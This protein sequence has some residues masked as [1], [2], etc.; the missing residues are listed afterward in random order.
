MK[1][2]YIY[3][4]LDKDTG[5]IAGYR[6]IKSNDK[7]KYTNDSS[8]KKY[9]NVKFDLPSNC[10]FDL[11]PEPKVFVSKLSGKNISAV[12]KSVILAGDRENKLDHF[13]I[14]DDEDKIDL[15]KNFEKIFSIK[16][17][18][19]VTT[20]KEAV[21]FNVNQE[22]IFSKYTYSS[23]RKILNSFNISNDMFRALIFAAFEAAASSSV[24]Y[25]ISKDSG[26]DQVVENEKLIW[27]IYSF[28]P[29]QLIE[30]LGFITYFKLIEPGANYRLNANIKLR[31]VEDNE[32]NRSQAAKQ[33]KEDNYVFNLSTGYYT[34]KNI[35]KNNSQFLGFLVDA[36]EDETANQT[37]KQF[38]ENLQH[39]IKN[40]DY[41]LAKFSLVDSLFLLQYSKSFDIIGLTKELAIN[42]NS[43]SDD[44]K[45]HFEESFLKSV[46]T[47]CPEDATG[48]KRY[49]KLF[50]EIYNNVPTVKN[51]IINYFANQ[52]S[53]DKS[54][55]QV[56]QFE[57]ELKQ[58]LETE[59]LTNPNYTDGGVFLINS[60]FEKLEQ[61]SSCT[62]SEVVDQLCE[63]ASISPEL[64]LKLDLEYFFEKYE[65]R[66]LS[67]AGFE[68]YVSN[69]Y[70]LKKIL[71][72][73]KLNKK[74]VAQLLE[75]HFNICFNHLKKQ[76]DYNYG[77]QIKRINAFFEVSGVVYTYEDFS[78]C[79]QYKQYFEKHFIWEIENLPLLKYL[80]EWV[81]KFTKKYS[82]AKF[83][84]DAL[85]QILDRIFENM[86]EQQI[87]SE[88][89]NWSDD[90]VSCINNRNIK[91]K[92]I[93]LKQLEI[94]EDCLEERKYDDIKQFLYDYEEF[95]QPA[96][97]WIFRI[98]EENGGDLSNI[99]KFDYSILPYIFK[100]DIG[101]I[102]SIL[103]DNIKAW[104]CCLQELKRAGIQYNP[105]DWSIQGNK[106]LLKEHSKL[107]ED[108]KKLFNVRGVSTD[109]GKIIRNLLLL[110]LGVSI[111]TH[112]SIFLYN[113]TSVT[114][115][116]TT[117]CTISASVSF[118]LLL[119]YGIFAGLLKGNAKVSVL[120]YLLSTITSVVFAFNAFVML[121]D[122][123]KLNNSVMQLYKD[124]Y[125]IKTD[126][127]K[128]TI[129][130]KKVA[131]KDK[132]AEQFV[133]LKG[134]KAYRFAVFK[135]DIVEI[136]FSCEDN[137]ELKEQKVFLNYEQYGGKNLVQL[138]MGNY[139]TGKHTIK[140]DAID[141]FGN[142]ETKT[143]TILSL[144]NRFKQY[145]SKFKIQ[146]Y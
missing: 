107:S 36:I 96:K 132:D 119:I 35:D 146:L 123:P 76:L 89:K 50:A 16:A 82:K 39:C 73:A 102:P 34:N 121:A 29:W 74:K 134:N 145:V 3:G 61:A 111:I 4:R 124:M 92:L 129:A 91:S 94:F 115:N 14:F 98:K 79:N 10:H 46:M 120:I 78:S 8:I 30:K 84:N 13:H 60:F 42:Y 43:F 88:L 87:L 11:R 56:M 65:D 55:L 140:I 81:F 12:G 130:I 51:Y 117:T 105:K 2:Q 86:S 80:S 126:S 22:D 25:F 28:L 15:C 93:K 122:F 20:I 110:Q 141:S 70:K 54:N 59:L 17:E 75:L 69:F 143:I 95:Q 128:P 72:N 64:I 38:Y 71:Q 33:E 127:E 90:L 37:I 131:V 7:G 101:L 137:L 99:K 83:M 133:E 53:S 135:G 113:F 66:P 67:N 27:L 138:N 47:S 44:M 45:K 40:G 136:D 1:Y 85:T 144:P 19:F 24:I 52:I 103:P 57:G 100:E 58:H 125:S 26:Y 9:L 41:S 139:R 112:F 77:N 104:V 49:F 97:S 18:N 32:E 142:E 63:I 48:K 118:V 116:V 62:I 23:K 106:K 31:F 6:T 114:T 109:G 68:Q 21:E 108:D 5:T